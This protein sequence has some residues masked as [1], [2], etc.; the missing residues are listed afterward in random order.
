VA[1]VEG[2]S[3]N[4]DE[5][6]TPDEEATAT[7]GA[8]PADEVVAAEAAELERPVVDEEEEEEVEP[9][10]LPF[11]LEIAG[12]IALPVIIFVMASGDLLGV[13]L[14]VLSIWTALYVIGLCLI[15]YILW[16]SR[17]SNTVYTVFLGCV[18]AAMLTA[19]YC[20]WMELMKYQ[21]DL[22]AREVKAK[23]G[24]SVP[25]EHGL[26]NYCAAIV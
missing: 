3:P 7:E 4:P 22:N 21:F 11:Y 6:K 5:L 18:L 1:N 19:S 13:G 15:A 12:L 8:V 20:L 2:E 25:V 24:M 23:I 17:R 14:N 26:A 16:M 9:S 10:K